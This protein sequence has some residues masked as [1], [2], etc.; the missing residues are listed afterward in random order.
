MEV[1]GR[2][3]HSVFVVPELGPVLQVETKDL[4]LVVESEAIDDAARGDHPQPD[5]RVVERPV[6]GAEEAGEDVARRASHFEADHDDVV[7]VA[8]PVGKGVSPKLPLSDLQAFEDP[9]NEAGAFGQFVVD[10]RLEG[11]YSLEQPALEFHRHFSK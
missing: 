3:N 5:A 9:S 4:S 2:K 8:K 10:E 11:P 7:E 6:C 1:I